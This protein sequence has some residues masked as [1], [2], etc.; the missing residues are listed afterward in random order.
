MSEPVVAVEGLTKLFGEVTAVDDLSLTV[1]RGQ[2]Y[3]VLGP[4]GAGKTTA[5]RILTGLERP[6]EGTT[7]LFGT[8]VVPWLSGVVAG[9]CD[10]GAGSVCPAAVGNDQPQAVVGSGR[11]PLGQRRS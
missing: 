8:T 10:G 4:N 3:G 6:T 1:E 2:V 11:E 9:R 5:L 7:R